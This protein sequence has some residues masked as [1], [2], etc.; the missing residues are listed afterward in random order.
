MNP[1]NQPSVGPH[2]A[3]MLVG[4]ILAALLSAGLTFLPFSAHCESSVSFVGPKVLHVQAWHT[5]SG[6]NEVRYQESLTDPSGSETLLVDGPSEP[7]AIQ[8]ECDPAE[9]TW[10]SHVTVETVDKKG[11]HHTSE[12]EATFE[13]SSLVNGTLLFSETIGKSGKEYSAGT[14]EVKSG[15]TL[16][17]DG[18][19][20]SG[21]FSANG[22]QLSVDGG[23]YTGVHFSARNG[24]SATITAGAQL[25]L[26]NLAVSES[27]SLTLQDDTLASG[28]SIRVYD[29]TFDPGNAANLSGNTYTYH[30]PALSGYKAL[31]T[32]TGKI[33][34]AAGSESATFSGENYDV[35]MGTQPINFNIS[36]CSLGIASP[37][38]ISGGVEDC[39]VTVG[40][41]VVPSSF[42]AKV[43]LQGLHLGSLALWGAEDCSVSDCEIGGSTTICMGAPELTGNVF[44]NNCYIFGGTGASLSQ[45]AFHGP[46]IFSGWDTNMARPTIFDND[47]LGGLAIQYQTTS[48]FD[49]EPTAGSI[50]IGRAYYGGLADRRWS[51]AADF[52]D[53]EAAIKAAG[54]PLR[55][56]P[57]RRT[58][59]SISSSI[60]S[61]P[62]GLPVWSLNSTRRGIGWLDGHPARVFWTGMARIG[63]NRS[64]RTFRHC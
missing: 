56:T 63:C 17:L 47:F 32:A 3:L 10:T 7:K 58:G 44:M 33:I 37:A 40:Q 18:T 49:G 14:V 29:G 4:F 60:H 48:F 26:G 59:M 55:I 53:P 25:S 9:G 22:G 31:H 19:W 46:L 30:D 64:T 24:G 39:S 41:P 8:I 38:T 34:L 62:S 43:V 35:V 52:L 6:T 1:P 45:N 42:T 51:M 57:V 20:A 21:G 27:G 5:P 54:Y 23:L 50:A 16:N 28:V 2:S 61:R 12:S 36:K 13:I 11:D 15:L